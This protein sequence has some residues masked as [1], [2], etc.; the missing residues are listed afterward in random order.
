MSIPQLPYSSAKD[1]ERCCTKALLAAY[2]AMH[3]SADVEPAADDMFT[4]APVPRAT[5]LGSTACVALTSAEQLIATMASTSAVVIS[6]SSEGLDPCPALLSSTPGPQGRE[7]CWQSG[8][9][10]GL[11]V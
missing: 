3:G 1:L 2:T 11:E 7:L 4:M 9:I 10:F 5:M 6:W 8:G